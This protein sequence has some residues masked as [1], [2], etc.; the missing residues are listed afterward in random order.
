[1]S[2]NLIIGDEGWDYANMSSMVKAF[3]GPQKFIDVIQVNAIQDYVDELDALK[4]V[5]DANLYKKIIVVGIIGGTIG[6]GT[7]VFIKC[8]KHF[9]KKNKIK[10]QI[11]DNQITES[12]GEFLQNNGFENTPQYYDMFIKDDIKIQNRLTQVKVE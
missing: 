3:G 8:K 6:I 9:Y 2:E 5:N 10:N 12:Y 4:S 11:S 7:F 1:M